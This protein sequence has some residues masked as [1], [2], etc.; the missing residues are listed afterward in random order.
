M[1][2]LFL[3]SFS[4]IRLAPFRDTRV[5]LGSVSNIAG[6]IATFPV[7]VGIS[8]SSIYESQLLPIS[9]LG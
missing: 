7:P 1:Y 3:S 5:L 4:D 8:H 6:I 9:L 2:E